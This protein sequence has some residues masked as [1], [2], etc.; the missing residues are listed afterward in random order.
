MGRGR[1]QEQ[2][3]EA[4]IVAIEK[5]NRSLFDIMISANIGTHDMTKKYLQV[6][7][8]KRKIR[9]A[10]PSIF[11]HGHVKKIYKLQESEERIARDN[12]T[13]PWIVRGVKT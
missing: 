9:E 11:D 8:D 10:A 13:H 1:T 3:E 7:L 6:L 2:I 12:K 5:G 4:M